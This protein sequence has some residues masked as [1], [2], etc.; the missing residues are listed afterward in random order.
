MAYVD[1]NDAAIIYGAVIEHQPKIVEHVQ[2][3]NIQIAMGYIWDEFT[4][5]PDPDD[6]TPEDIAYLVH[7]IRSRRK[8][9]FDAKAYK[10]AKRKPELTVVE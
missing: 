5:L 4:D 2:G 7:Q 10:K 3:M 8:D 9:A 1:P 6:M